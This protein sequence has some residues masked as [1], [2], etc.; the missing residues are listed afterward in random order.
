MAVNI[1]AAPALA[2]GPALATLAAA[3]NVSSIGGVVDSGSVAVIQ[4]QYTRTFWQLL[5]DLVAANI[6]T[7]LGVTLSLMLLTLLF[8][9]RKALFGAKGRQCWR[10]CVPPRWG[11]RIK[12]AAFLTLPKLTLQERQSASFRSP[13]A[14]DENPFAGVDPSTLS[15]RGLLSKPL[16]STF[17]ISHFS[18]SGE[19]E[20][21]DVPAF[22][23]GGAAGYDSGEGDSG[24]GSGG[25][26]GGSPGPTASNRRAMFQPRAA[27]VSPEAEK[28]AGFIP[29]GGLN[30]GGW[31]GSLLGG[32][33]GAAALGG[34][35]ARVLA[36]RNGRTP[37]PDS[38]SREGSVTGDALDNFLASGDA[39]SPATVLPGTAEHEELGGRS[40]LVLPARHPIE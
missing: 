6:R 14:V 38:F 8:C 22:E 9:S 33:A 2:L 5:W 36:S 28:K 40:T 3:M 15:P 31:M 24:S 25:R 18:P 27:W 7:V 12:A 29:A 21:E 37:N 26:M 11:Q 23:E 34:A 13:S 35:G 20:V 17:P 19:G 1:K 30:M 32:G 10:P 16:F 4:L 39:G